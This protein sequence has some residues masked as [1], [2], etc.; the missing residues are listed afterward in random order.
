[1]LTFVAGRNISETASAMRGAWRP[2][3][4][5]KCHLGLILAALLIAGYRILIGRLQQTRLYFTEGLLA[6]CK[7]YS[8][9]HTLVK[10]RY[11]RID[12]SLCL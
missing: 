11:V 1:M 12:L 8:Y 2:V 4:I 6:Y 7:Y 9:A 10:C 5:T 3:V